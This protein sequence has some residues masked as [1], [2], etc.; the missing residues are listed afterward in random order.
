MNDIGKA[1]P[2]LALLRLYLNY[3]REHL[4]NPDEQAPVGLILCA[5]KDSAVAKYSLG[6]LQ[7]KVLASE[8]RLVLPGE[9]LLANEIDRARTRIERGIHD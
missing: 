2:T 3:V 5:E 9:E 8:Y 4:T 1:A 7:N 6:N